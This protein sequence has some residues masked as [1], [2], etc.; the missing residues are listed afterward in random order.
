MLILLS[1]VFLLLTPAMLLHNPL[2]TKRHFM[3][4]YVIWM[5]ILSIMI[6]IQVQQNLRQRELGEVRCLSLSENEW[7]HISVKQ[8]GVNKTT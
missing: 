3:Y 6:C 5:N 7:H 2:T 4:Y 8:G 1:L